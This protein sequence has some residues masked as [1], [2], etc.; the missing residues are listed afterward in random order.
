MELGKNS[1]ANLRFLLHDDNYFAAM[2]DMWSDFRSKLST[3][4]NF[5]LLSLPKLREEVF[6]NARRK[7]SLYDVVT[8]NMPWL[9]EAVAN[10]VAQPLTEFL[11]SSSINPLDFHPNIWST[12]TWCG[13]QYGIPIYCTIEALSLRKDLFQERGLH[14]PTTFEAVIE[15]A[16][17]FHNPKRGMHGMVW[18]AARGMPISH[19]F[20]FFMGACG[21]PVINIPVN[22]LLLDYSELKGDAMRPLVLSESGRNTLAYM[23]ELRAVSPPDIL[24]TAWD[25]A[26]GYFMHGHASM[27][28]CQTMRA[29]RFE[30]DV[31]SVVKHKVA[32]C[33]HPH[34]PGGKSVSPIGGFLLTVPASLP[35]GPCG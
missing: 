16:K 25:K 28:Y 2:R 33:A 10:G 11:K 24:S 17:A 9:G 26:L 8:V 18:N 20:M 4:K 5:E 34:G 21:S 29:A 12:G 1:R 6:A 7:A 13:V 32:Y 22:R 19:S 14:H 27:I 35:P 23:H 31:E 15:A 3:R 30:Y